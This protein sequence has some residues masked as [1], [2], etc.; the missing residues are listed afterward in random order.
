MLFSTR[1]DGNVATVFIER[2]L[3]VGNRRELKRVFLEHE[4]LAGARITVFDCS[5]CSYMDS[6]GLGILVSL[7]K[8]AKKQGRELWIMNLQKEIETLFELAK[9]RDHVTVKEGDLTAL[10]A[11]FMEEAL[12]EERF[13]QA[14]LNYVRHVL[15]HADEHIKTRQQLVALLRERADL[16]EREQKTDDSPEAAAR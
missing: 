13:A 16:I 12:V 8:E 5:K 14:S 4:D 1:R 10:A 6:S 7:T 15:S 3:V 9:M 2:Q 11:A